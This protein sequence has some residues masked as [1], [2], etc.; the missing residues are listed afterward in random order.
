MDLRISL[1]KVSSGGGT[2]IQ[3]IQNWGKSRSNVEKDV[4]SDGN[5]YRNT[6][7]RQ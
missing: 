4:L 1:V 7:G 5:I 3:V 2:V 6:D